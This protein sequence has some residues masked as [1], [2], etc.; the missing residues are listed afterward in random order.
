MEHPWRRRAGLTLGMH[1][2]SKATSNLASHLQHL[3]Q[4][5][6]PPPPSPL[7]CPWLA[8]QASRRAR[9]PPSRQGPGCCARP[10]ILLDGSHWPSHRLGVDW[11]GIT[12]AFGF[13]QAS[14][15]VSWPPGRGILGPCVPSLLLPHPFLSFLPVFALPNFGL[16]SGISS[17]VIISQLLH[18]RS[19]T[20]FAFPLPSNCP[21][22][23]TTFQ[24]GKSRTR[25]ARFRVPHAPGQQRER[26]REREPQAPSTTRI[27]S[28]RRPRRRVALTQL[29]LLSSRAT[30]SPDFMFSRTHTE[31]SSY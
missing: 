31:T 12:A 3:I 8:A 17:A 20:R 9:L 27:T 28:T 30:R 11:G 29:L 26:E 15:R 22:T 1:P 14:H 2:S 21:L 19:S 16:T 6:D 5:C 18:G 10:R 4:T 24:L 23:P 7:A 13:S 25:P